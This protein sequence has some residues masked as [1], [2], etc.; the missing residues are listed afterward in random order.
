MNFR[1]AGL[2]GDRRRLAF[3]SLVA[4]AELLSRTAAAQGAAEP[5]QNLALDFSL[6]A[7]VL[8]TPEVLPET[9][10]ETGS[11]LSAPSEARSTAAAKPTENQ[12]LRV[13]QRQQ[14]PIGS[15]GNRGLAVLPPP[16]SP[17][18]PAPE[19]PDA[20]S[21][22]SGNEE[23][24][25]PTA[26]VTTAAP[27][28]ES[29]ALNFDPQ[30]Q[31][32]PAP[33][34]AVKPSQPVL[35]EKPSLAGFDV[36][37]QALF[38]HGAESLVARAVGSAEGTRTPEGD[39]N[40]AYYGHV[41]PGNGVWNLGTFSYQHGAKTPEDADQRQLMRLQTQF[42]TL[43]MQA[44]AKGI[45][46]TLEEK[47]NGIDLANQAPLA[48]L[49]RGGY[50]DWL[51][52]AHVMGLSGSE[53]VLW[54]RTRSFIDP[55]TQT[56]NAPGLGNNLYSISRDQ[57]RRMQAIARAIVA[58]P[59]REVEVSA[60]TPEAAAL[61]PQDAAL[62]PL[63]ADDYA[64]AEAASEQADPHLDLEDEPAVIQKLFTSEQLGQP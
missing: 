56:W 39:R 61:V 26:E 29:L 52:Q 15:S 16:P 54:A 20:A 5:R 48:A 62:A 30:P 6:K 25:P 41:D 59:R 14:I 1:F 57:E 27:L 18:L 47:L 50:I 35:E 37:D 12:L 19:R 31:P 58:R 45:N 38:E 60:A 8:S 10:P 17:S 4:I 13:P 33:R 21:L 3:V 40:P 49:D 9:G 7:Q 51:V 63:F 43:K 44:A 53:A 32:Q 11:K 34:Q 55:D 28:A 46:L 64:P 22:E 23:P 2:R 36:A 42:Q 24:S